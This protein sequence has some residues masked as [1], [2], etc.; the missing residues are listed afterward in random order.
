MASHTCCTVGKSS[1]MATMKKPES[2]VITFQ[3]L[4]LQYPACFLEYRSNEEQSHTL[5][6]GAVHLDIISHLSSPGRSLSVNNFPTLGPG[7]AGRDVAQPMDLSKFQEHLETCKN[8]FYSKSKSETR[9]QHVLTLLSNR[10]SHWLTFS[11]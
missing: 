2:A 10:K 11:C 7:A 9:L 1:F 8:T 4:I 5:L 6:L 3:G